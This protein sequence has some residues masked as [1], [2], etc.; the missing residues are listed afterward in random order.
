MNIRSVSHCPEQSDVSCF[1]LTTL[2]NSHFDRTTVRLC[3]THSCLPT[4]C[5]CPEPS[6]NLRHHQHTLP[7]QLAANRRLVCWGPKYQ[8]LPRSVVCSSRPDPRR[9]R[10]HSNRQTAAGAPWSWPCLCFNWPE[11]HFLA[12][13]SPP[14]SEFSFTGDARKRAKVRWEYHSS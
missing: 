2:L 3:R 6:G 4:K 11:F 8:V 1:M 13:F 9:S 12:P 14:A 5:R 10:W 7:S